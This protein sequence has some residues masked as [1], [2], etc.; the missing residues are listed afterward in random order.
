MANHHLSKIRVT[1][2][3][4]L[5]YWILP[6]R[7]QIVLS[8]IDL[9]F[10]N[11]ATSA[12]KTRL[13]KAFYSHVASTL[14]ELFWMNSAGSK[15]LNKKIEIYG[16]EHLQKAV[17]QR[18]GVFLLTGHLG[19]WEL[20]SVLGSSRLIPQFGNFNIVRR[21]IKIKWL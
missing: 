9:V 10:K 19:S 7:K 17:D 8:N 15:K 16:L 20:T 14:K 6:L 21:P 4:L 11:T 18:K 5:F 13:A 3:G 2:A 12:E 1:F